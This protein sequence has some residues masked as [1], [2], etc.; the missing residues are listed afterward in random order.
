MIVE[1]DAGVEL[2]EMPDSG[3]IAEADIPS[4]NFR[5]MIAANIE[6][7]CGITSAGQVKCWGKCDIAP[8]CPE[9]GM[10]GNNEGEAPADMQAMDLG[11]NTPV[12]SIKWSG[13][14]YCILT[15]NNYAKCWGTNT[16]SLGFPSENEVVGGAPEDMGASLPY[17]NVGSGLTIRKLDLGFNHGCALLTNGKVKCWGAKP[18]LG[19]GLSGSLL[20]RLGDDPDEMGNNL[21]F[22]DLGSH[23]HDVIDIALAG[24][25]SCAL[26]EHG[27]VKCWGR[28]S[29]GVLGI[30][31]PATILGMSNTRGDA[32][33]E[34]GDNLPFVELGDN[35]FATQLTLGVAHACILTSDQRV[36]CWGANNDW[37][38]LGQG[39]NDE[40]VGTDPSHMGNNLA[41]TD[42]GAVGNVI[43]LYSK[44][45][46]TCALFD[47]GKVKCWGDN[48][49]GMLGY[50]DLEQRGSSPEHMGD[51]LPFIDLGTDF[52]VTGLT[53][54]A[55][56]TCASS[57]T[58]AIKCWGSNPNGE[59]GLGDT[60]NR[61]DEYGEM[62]DNLP[63]IQI[64]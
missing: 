57:D 5:A 18:F 24:E 17:L 40:N 50:E 30:G 37:G 7:T 45:T 12:A 29:A 51:N 53:V 43:A 55:L 44:G 15:T 6:R 46:H 48:W 59:L 49:T 38:F 52:F 26:F 58:G 13:F 11:F 1:N 4:E 42:L 60:E 39:H 64:D 41:Y 2:P 47:I 31:E 22:V 34:M 35:V 33:D 20:D 27:Q 9:D 16:G 62:G 10:W 61:G 63:V 3:I 19:L 8:T 54:G 25:D 14:T 32:P 56:S 28:N 23:G 36:K 21:P